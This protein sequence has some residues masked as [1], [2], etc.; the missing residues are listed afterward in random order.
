[1]S[2]QSQVPKL[3]QSVIEDVINNV[4]E[5]FVDEGRKYEWKDDDFLITK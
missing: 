4:R 5:A 1:M 3:Y 2:A